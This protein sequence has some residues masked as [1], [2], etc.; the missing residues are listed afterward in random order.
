MRFTPFFDSLPCSTGQNLENTKHVNTSEGYQKQATEKKLPP[1]ICIPSTKENHRMRYVIETTN[2]MRTGK[3]Q[4]EPV[5]SCSYPTKTME[6]MRLEARKKHSKR[7]HIQPNDSIATK[8]SDNPLITCK[9]QRLKKLTFP[10]ENGRK[11]E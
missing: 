2:V 6:S 9:L 1:P 11:V 10:E 4:I 3:K 7:T 8:N 5:A